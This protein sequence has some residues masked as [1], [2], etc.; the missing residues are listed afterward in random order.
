MTTIKSTFTKNA[1]GWT[2]AGD[3]QT[4]EWLPEGGAKGGYIHWV[5][6]AAGADS[7]WQAPEKFT[8]DLSGFAG[9]KLSFDWYSSGDNYQTGDV[10]LTGAD[11]TVLVADAP[12]PGTSWTPAAIKLSAANWHVGTIDGDVATKQEL[13]GVLS[14]VTSLQIRAEHVSGGEDGGLDNVSLKSKGAAQDQAFGEDR[15]AAA[16]ASFV[17][18]H[19]PL[20]ASHIALA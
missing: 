17:E 3:V 18:A 2:I 20:D 14:N 16:H 19:H 13:A 7:Y 1:D 11:G 10:I 5:D 15:H 9:G 6:A 4:F 8:G 12:D